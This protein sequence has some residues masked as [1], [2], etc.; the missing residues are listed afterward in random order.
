MRVHCTALLSLRR[1]LTPYAWKQARQASRPKQPPK[2][3]DLHP[4][5]MVLVLMTWTTGDSEAERF[6]T[7]R[8]C[9]VACHQR[10]KRPGRSFAGFQKAVTK[11]PL[12][13]L[14]A[15]FAAVRGPLLGLYRRCCADNGF[16]VLA[17]DGSRLQCPRSGELEQRLG[18]CGKS[19][20][21]PMLQVTALALL[22]L[23]VLWAWVVG[24]GTAS[25]HE[26]LRQL[27]TTLPQAT[28]LVADAGYLGYDLYADILHARADF[29]VRLSSRA[30][31]YTL[32]QERREGY[33]QGE[34]YYWP[35][36]AQQ[37]GRPPLRLRLI[38]VRGKKHDVWLLTSVLDPT[39]LSRRQAG[40]I[41]RWR[42][43]IEGVYRTYKRTLPKVKLWSRTEALACREA[44][45]S[46]F[47]LQLLLLQGVRERRTGDVVVLAGARQTLLRLRGEITVAIAG[48]G[49]R[50]LR[51]YQER[52]GQVPAGGR[53]K[54]TRRKWPRRKDHKPP[55]PP[56][57]R[58][59]PKRLKAK[60]RKR[61]HAA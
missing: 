19:D 9:Y 26:Q 13:V 4:L 48:L 49:P 43:R 59:L 20:S 17:C 14:H 35:G 40:E 41:Y 57:M 24:P 2:R 50:Q 29:V 11:L 32:R 51:W 61:F 47:A 1:W 60:L 38:R 3:W 8:A 55:K 37:S 53:G 22:P 18:C 7:A 23:G 6:A 31:L 46:L 12:A 42:W 58:V 34:V 56:K 36:T 16:V 15:L 39:R 5:L 33:R 25:E 10:Q 28:L 21:A 27:L 30:Y 54:K 52:L 44:E 45:V